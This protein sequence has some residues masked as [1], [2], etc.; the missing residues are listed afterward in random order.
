MKL[1]PKSTSCLLFLLLLVELPV[2]AMSRPT[3]VRHHKDGLTKLFQKMLRLINIVQ[4]V[5]HHLDTSLPFEHSLTS[6]P[7]LNFRPKDLAAVKANSTLSQLSS[8]L[9]SFKLHFDW[10]LYWQNQSG[11]VSN[12]VKEISDQIQSISIL[13]QRLTDSPAQG[14]VLSLPPLKT[15]WDIYQTSA[16]IH[17]RLLAFCNWYLRALRV[18][19]YYANN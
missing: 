14:T 2:L 7:T 13:Q 6:L 4:G 8:G 16:E 12:K 10:L 18:L 3:P 1:L 9:H 11:L 15:A 5:M 17:K 19:I